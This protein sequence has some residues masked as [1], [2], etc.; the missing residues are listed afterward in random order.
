[1][2]WPSCFQE[3]SSW[4]EQKPS[5]LPV[6]SSFS[7]F[8]NSWSLMT[9]RSWEPSKMPDF[10]FSMVSPGEAWHEY[11][12]QPP[13][14][15]RALVNRL[16]KWAWCAAAGGVSCLSTRGLFITLLALQETRSSRTSKYFFV[17]CRVLSVISLMQ[18]KHGWL[19]NPDCCEITKEID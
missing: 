10:N 19:V 3:S 17:Q 13:S 14:L 16:Q 9:W 18:R 5:K 7:E 8:S 4:Q 2:F 15:S 1:M 11:V 12:K 6:S